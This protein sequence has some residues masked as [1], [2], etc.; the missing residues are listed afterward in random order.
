MRLKYVTKTPSGTYE[1]RRQV[2]THLRAA[3]GKR[4]IKKVLGSTEA[5]AMAA[6]SRAF[7]EAE[8]ILTKAKAPQAHEENVR[9]A[10]MDFHSAKRRVEELG[11]NPSAPVYSDEGGY[12]AESIARDVLIESIA[13][14][15]PV[16]EEGTPDVTSPIDSMMIAMIGQGAK[17]KAP[18]AT[19][20]DAVRIYI[21]E[22]HL[23][24]PAEKKQLLHVQL[25]AREFKA[26]LND[27][28]PALPDLRR[29]HGRA[30][31]D[32]M[33][34]EKARSPES[35]ERYLNTV[36]AIINMAIKE[37]DLECGNP[38]MGLEV[39]K[40]PT[41]TRKNKR[42]PLPTD[43]LRNVTERIHGHAGKELQVIWDMLAGTGCRPS[44]VTGLRVEDVHVGGPLPHIRIEWHDQR[45]VKDEITQRW[46]P[47]VG[48]ALSAARAALEL[49]TTGKRHKD[50]A[51][52]MLFPTYGRMGGAGG[53]SN[54][55]IPKHM[56]LITTNPKHVLHSLRH[57]AKDTLRKAGVALEVQNM[58]L[59]QTN[60]GVGEGYGGDEAILEVTSAAMA[61]A[62]R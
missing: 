26:A 18:M 17:F 42:H 25:I 28:P 14:K 36:R 5:Q 44:E 13:S 53:A 29:E 27:M 30:V 23:L 15:Y 22:K 34:T 40:D 16:G 20:D 24:E 48:A 8:K 39:K 46:V 37:F 6:Y 33:L 31:R 49:T 61:K 2:P 43:V 55:I 47:L 7:Q 51:A 59:G 1:F 45:R 56:R 32:F 58:I 12:D 54:V 52:H 3:V 62:F 21:Q 60:G 10:L 57:N 4:E 50:T 11:I 19:F 41:A 9:T 35:V 38:F